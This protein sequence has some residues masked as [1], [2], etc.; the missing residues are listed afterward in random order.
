[1]FA[2]FSVFTTGNM[3]IHRETAFL[4]ASTGCLDGG[5]QGQ[6]VGLFGNGLDD[7]NV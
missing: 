6:Q 2:I 7:A 4:F 3:E 5:T 1:M